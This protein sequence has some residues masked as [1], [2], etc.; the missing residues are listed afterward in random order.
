MRAASLVEVISQRFQTRQ[1][2][3][4]ARCQ[5]G[6]EYVQFGYYE[7]TTAPGG[8]HWFETEAEACADLLF[9]F[10][11]YVAKVMDAPGM[12]R[13]SPVLYWRYDPPHIFWHPND[14][15]LWDQS[16]GTL[17]TRLVLTANPVVWES[18]QDYLAASPQTHLER[19]IQGDPHGRPVQ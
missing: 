16:L 10:D 6:D 9:K 11:A 7:G 18:L 8:R 12:S 13:F 2:I 14:G 4:A 15:P 3:H 5:T 17:R 1:G 19:S